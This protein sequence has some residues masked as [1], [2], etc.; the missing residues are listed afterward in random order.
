[1][2]LDN[3]LSVFYLQLSFVKYRVFVSSLKEIFHF[4]LIGLPISDVRSIRKPVCKYRYTVGNKQFLIVLLSHFL[5]W[6]A[7]ILIS[8]FQSLKNIVSPKNGEPLISPIQDLITATHLL[9]LKDVFFT[10]DQACQ[11]AS[12]ILAGSHLNKPIRL[13]PPA[14]QWVNTMLLLVYYSY[15]L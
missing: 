13:P 14:V 11:L 9:T 12:Q 6:P 10:R 5:M 2:L 7:L 3:T 15:W 1:M 8:A 4:K